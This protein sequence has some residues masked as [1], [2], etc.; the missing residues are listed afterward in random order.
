MLTKFPD[1]SLPTA[2]NRPFLS[3]EAQ[4]DA[5]RFKTQLTVILVGIHPRWTTESYEHEVPTCGHLSMEAAM[6]ERLV[7]APWNSKMEGID[8][9]QLADEQELRIKETILTESIAPERMLT[10]S[11][12][13]AIAAEE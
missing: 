8:Q 11:T 4:N 9:R 5:S 10:E 7:V 3:G 2:P 12:F 1:E 13:A 6:G